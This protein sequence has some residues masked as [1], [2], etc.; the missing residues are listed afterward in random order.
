MERNV[1]SGYIKGFEIPSFDSKITSFLNEEGLERNDGNM[2]TAIQ[3]EQKKVY[4]IIQTE[5][6]SDYMKL[7]SFL[8]DLDLV[9][10]LADSIDGKDGYDSFFTEPK[11]S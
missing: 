3:N 9:D 10:Q 5:G 1:E 6:L 7:V 8:T 11:S 4:R 2:V